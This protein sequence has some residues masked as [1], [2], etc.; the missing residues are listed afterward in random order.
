MIENTNVFVFIFIQ[1][2]CICTKLNLNLSKKTNLTKNILSLGFGF[3][4]F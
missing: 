3:E 1:H 4:I 2:W